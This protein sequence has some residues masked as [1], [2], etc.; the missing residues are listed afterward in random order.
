MQFAVSGRL[1]SLFSM[2]AKRR[3]NIHSF[4]RR[5]AG[6]YNEENRENG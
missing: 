2:A 1:F 4:D 3:K 6:G 5:A